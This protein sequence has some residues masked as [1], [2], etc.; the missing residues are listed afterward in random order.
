M[1]PLFLRP[2]AWTGGFLEL[3]IQLGARSDARLLAALESLWGHPDVEGCYETRDIEP[4]R[5]TPLSPDLRSNGQH[6][7]GIASMPNGSRVPCGT[8]VIRETDGGPDWLDF[9]LPM[10]SLG[11]A[12]PVGAYPFI[13]EDLGVGPW[14]A[15]VEDWL[16]AIGTRTFLAVDFQLAIIGHEVLGTVD[17]V[18]LQA[19]GVP[20]ERHV[21]YL[22]P[23]QGQVTYFRRTVERGVGYSFPE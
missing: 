8:C 1:R 17:A 12:Y 21:S 4:E 15:E 13:Q 6:L 19:Q 5:Q 7:Y 10:G 20:A 22:W 14:L 3:A 11:L 16:A 2:D 23:T 18:S 9:Y